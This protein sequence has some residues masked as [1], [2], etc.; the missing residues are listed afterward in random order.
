M[1]RQ[2]G[3]PPKGSGGGAAGGGE[4]LMAWVRSWEG[5]LALLSM[6]LLIFQGTALSLTLRFSRCLHC[7]NPSHPHTD[8]N[9]LHPACLAAW[10]ACRRAAL[11]RC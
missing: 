10:W 7:P 4:S 9:S 2:P 1:S 3:T 6:S 11:E 5:G 8:R